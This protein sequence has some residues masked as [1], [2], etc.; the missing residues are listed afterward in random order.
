MV[1]CDVVCVLTAACKQ[2]LQI[3]VPSMKIESGSIATCTYLQVDLHVVPAM[4]KIYVILVGVICKVISM[5][6][7][8]PT[9]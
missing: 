4:Y 6:L 7:A 2:S 3:T 9:Q 1:S 5:Q 8:P